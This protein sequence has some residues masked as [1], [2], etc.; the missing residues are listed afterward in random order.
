NTFPDNP[1]QT[2]ESIERKNLPLLDDIS[3]NSYTFS[4]QDFDHRNPGFQSSI[5]YKNDSINESNSDDYSFGLIDFKKAE[6]EHKESLTDF[7]KNTSLN[8]NDK[9]FINDSYTFKK[10]KGIFSK[11]MKK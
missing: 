11:W 9:N 3:L 8:Y 2:P 6:I 1:Y 5:N 7:L 4:S 10:K